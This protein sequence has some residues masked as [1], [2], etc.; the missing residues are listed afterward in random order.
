VGTKRITGT[1]LALVLAVACAACGAGVPAA[2]TVPA[3]PGVP[4]ASAAATAPAASSASSAPAGAS[5]AGPPENVPE[6]ADGRRFAVGVR[7]LMLS[8]GPDRPLRTLIF[9][10]A[11]ATG[12]TAPDTLW[13]APTDTGAQPQRNAAPSAGRF[14]LVLFSH[15]LH[16]SPERYAPA[17]A[18]WAAAGFVVAA[19]A[20]PYTNQYTKHFYRSDI[21]HQPADANYVLRKVRCLDRTAGDPLAGHLDIHRVAAVGHSAGGYTTTGLFASGHSRW[22]RAGVV[23]AGWLAP[24]AYGG[25]PATMLFLQ[26]DSDTVVPVAQG[27]HAYNRVPWTKSYVLL[28]RSYHAEYMLPGGRE[29]PLM[30]TTVTDF[31]RWTLDGD[32][33]AHLRLPVTSFP[34]EHAQ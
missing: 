5:P 34:V 8:R 12:P 3:T 10:P 30:D 32:E 14:P 21:I 33:A 28:P 6:P 16:G 27:R 24:G 23:I 29:Y 2:P 19:P 11:A 18:S 1:A 25:P 26:G 15:G 20:Y 7:T 22:L 31:L 4:A 13:A 17:A 9:Y